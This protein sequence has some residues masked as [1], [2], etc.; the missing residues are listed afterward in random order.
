[1]LC[2]LDYGRMALSS[3]SLQLSVAE[4][5]AHVTL[6]FLAGYLAGLLGFFALRA[7]AELGRWAAAR[8]HVSPRLAISL[9]LATA[10]LVVIVPVSIA[11]FQGRGIRQ[12]S[13]ADWGPWAVSATAWVLCGVAAWGIQTLHASLEGHSRTLARR[14]LAGGA[15]AILLALLLYCDL[16]LFHGLYEYLHAVLMALAFVVVSL[17]LYVVSGGVAWSGQSARLTR[18]AGVL[19]VLCLGVFAYASRR[20]EAGLADFATHFAYTGR[21]ISLARQV[22]DWDRDGYSHLLGH[23]DAAALNG[24]IR[25]L[26]VD[27]PDNGTD[28]DGVFGDLSTAEL[29]AARQ[30]LPHGR[31]DPA[32]AQ[33][34]TLQGRALNGAAAPPNL[35]L[36]TID[37]LRADRVLP[38]HAGDP[39]SFAAFKQ[40]SVRFERAFAS[41]SYTQ[42]SV[43]MMMTGRYDAD[44]TTASLFDALQA[45]G[46][47]TLLAFAETPYRILEASQPN[48]VA[49]FDQRVVIPDREPGDLAVFHSYAATRPTS[50]SI[51]ANALQLLEANR[52]RRTCTWVYLFDVHQ[53]QQLR[54]PEVVGNTSST[55]P[56]R[57]DSA[58]AYTLKQVSQLLDGL[59]RLG[60]ADTTAVVLS[61]DHGEGLGEKGVV[62]HTRRV[63]NPLLHVPLLIRAPGMDPRVIGETQVGLIDL[64]PTLLDLLDS[65]PGLPNVDGASLLPL[66]LGEA[67]EHVVFTRERDY[68]AV[69]GANYKLVLDRLEGRYRLYDLG[70]DYA[71]ERSLFELP[72]YARI[73]RDLYYSYQAGGIGPF[74]SV[75]R[76]HPSTSLTN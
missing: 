51:V 2:V 71:E 20:Y 1:M 14:A 68:Q 44:R 72:G 49:S 55:D 4:H 46:C 56:A 12:T 61:G 63:H 40:G 17:G 45:A 59:E 62:G 7:C 5:L 33:Y 6:M 29:D 30:K 15:A 37:T 10:C 8:S 64:A 3:L 58:V 54:D 22:T 39:R 57:Y 76:S 35:L 32:R 43:T 70:S 42:A 65:E 75:P 74:R 11:L 60:L 25:P 16:Y 19:V 27:V 67:A 31:S 41:S 21:V 23:E 13:I 53:W 36:I 73:A 9:V 48:V 34:R 52:E 28:E 50:E 47:T 26:A 69:F 24:R 38:E 66:M 18:L